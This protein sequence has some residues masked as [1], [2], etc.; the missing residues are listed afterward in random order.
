MTTYHVYF[1][2][3]CRKDTDSHGGGVTGDVEK[4]V[5]KLERDQSTRGLERF[6]RPYLKKSIGRQGRL[7]IEEHLNGDDVVLCLARYFIRGS[8]EYDKFYKD[9]AG[10]YDNN[11]I[12]KNEVKKFLENRKREPL[13]F[14]KSLSDSESAYLHS[15]SLSTLHH[16]EDGTYLESYDWSERISQS[17][18]KNSLV[19]Y[20]ELI[21]LGKLPEKEVFVSH[22]KNPSIKI[23]YRHFP[24]H[25]LTFLIAPVDSRNEEDES[26]LREEY[27]NILDPAQVDV[28]E[29]KRRSRRA[30]PAIIACD[31]NI[32]RKVQDSNEANLALSPEEASIL[33]LV[34]RPG[35]DGPRYP[36]FIN[37]RPGSGKSTIL[38][39]LFSE[40][41]ERHVSSNKIDASVG[42][43][44][45][46]TY[47][48]QLL[49]QARSSVEN[50]LTCGAKTL[51][52]GEEQSVSA[53]LL[54]RSFRNFREFLLDQLPPQ[55]GEKFIPGKYIGFE[56]FRKEWESE[57]RSRPD[58]EVRSIGPELAWHA[59]RTFIKG[60]QDESGAEIDPEFY[61]KELA[62]DSKSIPDA[63]FKLIHEKIWKWYQEFC[64]N[65]EYWDDQDLV[66]SVLEHSTDKLSRYPAV[67]CDEAQDFTKIE[68]ELIER[69]SLYSD[70]ALP[71]SHLAKHVPFAFAGDPFQ[72]LNPT[73]FNWGAM[74]ASFHNNIA[75]QL[76]G[77]GKLE[78]NFQELSF[79]YRSLEQI[80]K[81][82][83]LIQLLRAVVLDIK[84]LR[85]QQ[86]WTHRESVTPVWFR[87]DD[88]SC[89]SKIRDQ[90]ELVIIIPCQENGEE[91]YVQND[92]FLSDFA[93]Q[94]G[95]ISRNILSPARAKGL[96]YDRVLLYRFGDEA[97]KRYPEL[98]EGID[99]PGRS[100]DETEQRLAWEYFL[101]QFYVAVSRARKRLFVV[102]SDEALKEFWQ[103]AMEP[104]KQSDL[105]ELYQNS[106][107]WNREDIGGMVQG[108]DISWEEDRD[109][110]LDLAR[111]WREQ[112]L[113]QRDPYQ[114]RLA[115]SNFERAGQPEEAR[116]CEAIAYEFDGDFVKAGNSFSMLR[117]ASDACRCYWAGQDSDAVIDLVKR[118]SEI[119]T[120]PRFLAA[121]VIKRKNNT[122]G[123]IDAV[124]T[125]LESVESP[126]SSA[127]YGDSTDWSWFFEKFIP[128]VRQAIESSKSENSDWKPLVERTSRILHRLDISSKT[129]PDLV[130][131]Y[132]LVGDWE[133]AIERWEE[134]SPD[135]RNEPEWLLRARAKKESYPQNIPFLARLNDHEAVLEAW[136]SDGRS[137]SEKTPVSQ[138]LKSATE[139]RD[140]SAIR[141]LLPRCS[142]VERI[143]SAIQIEEGNTSSDLNGAIPVAIISWLEASSRWG[144]IVTFTTSQKTS[145]RQLDDRLKAL[146]IGWD[147]SVV[148]AAAVR[149]FARS[150]RLASEK[151]ES[152]RTI[153]EFLK[154]HLVVNNNA[155]KKQQ[156]IMKEVHRLVNIEEVG[157]AFERAFRLTFALEYYERCFK[158]GVVN[159]LLS[160]SPED[161]KFARQRWLICKRRLGEQEGPRSERHMN[162]AEQKES[163]WKLP[164]DHEPKYPNLGPMISLN[165]PA[166]QEGQSTIEPS[167]PETTQQD[168]SAPNGQMPKK[169]SGSTIISVDA[170]FVVD[171]LTLNGSMR[172]KKRRIVLTRKDTEDEVFCGPQKV[173][174]EDVSVKQIK[175]DESAK[176]WLIEEWKIQCE[177]QFYKSSSI[178]RFR[179]KED[180]LILGFEF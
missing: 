8:S 28:G 54:N 172:T 98:M 146:K 123:Q 40:H 86:C 87:S 4:F 61:E 26:R 139:M 63:T 117:Q 45:Y 68:L 30:Y 151:P 157:A 73:G 164:I 127:A 70:R 148:I 108:D 118:F 128:K 101:N 168:T 179:T 138:I 9:T 52:D 92:P 67:F 23:L 167:R 82:A 136:R 107:E 131:L 25:N 100:T 57:R 76:D 155:G 22:K 21:E 36:L 15:Q 120:D 12:P 38:Q 48:G 19:R 173:S 83:N 51:Q 180:A 11:Q 53:E 58:R 35:D 7:V 175:D 156:T 10:Y 97:V 147:Q 165:I 60:M 41:L 44:L 80:V 94:N 103:F 32:W 93:L 81:L 37:G 162:E 176:A 6:P 119:G 34:L 55:I 69:L 59:I 159:R 99:E 14:K 134:C 125:A 105:L 13:V 47:S 141:D 31:E 39:Y 160:L 72:T 177:I 18:A 27:K 153:S 121:N 154:Q 56:Q 171:G 1:T 62:R 49:E 64:I 111:H 24:E 113:A 84:G 143:L 106:G 152:Q 89:K 79:N 102:D 132:Y 43:P 96:E 65:G 161:V 150:E 66:R 170:Q 137:I 166:P 74:K 158:G 46:L 112:G 42:P 88:A 71:S 20:Y 140:L 115:K 5:E 163:E 110:P 142:D 124:L 50:I 114:L 2:E 85:P 3:Q 130:E 75:Q 29:I 149:V 178:I 144:Q 116:L 77:S 78:F 17:W 145:H 104:K 90:D 33:E 174:S 169:E 122:A 126:S 109:K 133:T 91:D 95:Q 135:Q 16:T 129:Y